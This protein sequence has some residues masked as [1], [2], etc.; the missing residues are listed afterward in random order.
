MMAL[1]HRAFGKFGECGVLWVDECPDKRR[2]ES[3]LFL[4][5]IGGYS[6][7]GQGEGPH[8]KLALL[9]S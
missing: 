4:L 6:K 2:P 9:V 8:Q 7:M 5:A 1:E 3:L